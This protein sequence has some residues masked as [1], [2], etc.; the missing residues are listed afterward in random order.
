M[1]KPRRYVRLRYNKRFAKAWEY[2]CEFCGPGWTCGYSVDQ[3]IPAAVEHARTCPAA[4]A[5]MERDY[6]YDG[7][8]QQMS[9]IADLQATNRDLTQQLEHARQLL[10]AALAALDTERDTTP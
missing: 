8:K 9:T 3:V 1:S 7:Y 10:W 4:A 2:R 5:A 6:Y